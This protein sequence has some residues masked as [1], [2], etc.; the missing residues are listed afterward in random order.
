MLYTEAGAGI[1]GIILFFLV[2]G[3]VTMVAKRRAVA[4]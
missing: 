3:I 4:A 2:S 1:A